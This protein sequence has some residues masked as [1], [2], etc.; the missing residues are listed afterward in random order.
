MITTH[1]ALKLVIAQLNHSIY[2]MCIFIIVDN[3]PESSFSEV[4]HV[5]FV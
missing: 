3:K 4:E 5:V 2:S 1:S